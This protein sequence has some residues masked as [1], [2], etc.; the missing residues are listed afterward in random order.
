MLFC[1]T[2]GGDVGDAEDLAIFASQL[3]ALGVPARVAVGSVPEKPGPNLQFD[4]AP[5]LADGGLR[6]GD[7]LALLAA[8]RLT[9][10]TLVRLRRLAD[11]VEVTVRAFGCFAAPAGRARRAGAAL[12]RLRPRAR[13]P[14]RHAFRPRR[15]TPG[16]VFGVP[17]RTPLHGR[18]A[19]SA[20]DPP[21]RAGPEGPAAGRGAR[22]AG[23]APQASG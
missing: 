22:G 10:D 4:L 6:P 12:L 15:R 11:G 17:R 2:T 9:D 21:R 3:A 20:A 14:R 8:D 16:P 7:G 18:H 23:A 1:E 19:R 5:R 13:A